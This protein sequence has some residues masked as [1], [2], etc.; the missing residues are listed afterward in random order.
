MVTVQ[1][2][3]SRIIDVNL[4]ISV[5]VMHW[6]NVEPEEVLQIF[7]YVTELSFPHFLEQGGLSKDVSVAFDEEEGDFCL[8]TF[9]GLEE[10]SQ[11]AGISF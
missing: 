5:P 2:I 9:H 11:V 4:E 8:P 7:F 6:H 10:R 3:K 1:V